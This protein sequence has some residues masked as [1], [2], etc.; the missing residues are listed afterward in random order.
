MFKIVL[1]I[2]NCL[3]MIFPFMSVYNVVIIS[4]NLDGYTY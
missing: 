1:G 4:Y 3:L 2:P